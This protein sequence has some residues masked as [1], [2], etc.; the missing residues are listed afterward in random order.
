MLIYF[1]LLL[2]FV[3]C[4]FIWLNLFLHG[5]SASHAWDSVTSLKGFGGVS[6]VT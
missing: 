3:L 2:C 1:F 6:D 5:I 4:I